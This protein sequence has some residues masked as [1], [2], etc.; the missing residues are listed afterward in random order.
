MRTI[1]AKPSLYTGYITECA[2]IFLSD[3]YYSCP[4]LSPIPH[5]LILK[6]TRKLS[7]SSFPCHIALRGLTNVNIRSPFFFFFK[8]EPLPLLLYPCLGLG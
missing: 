3:P 1:M 6:H 2:I 5:T 7:L 4:Q 8:R